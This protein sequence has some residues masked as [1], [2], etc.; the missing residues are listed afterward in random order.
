MHPA[1]SAALAVAFVALSLSAPLRADEPAATPEKAAPVPHPERTVLPAD[2]VSVTHHS[3]TV[4]GRQLAYRATAGVLTIA[5]ADP[6]P[7]GRIFYMSYE[8]EGTQKADRPVTFAFNGGPGAASAYLH[9][10]ALGPKRLALND[11]GTVPPPPARFVDNALTWLAFTD[12]V[13][14]DPIGTGY[15]RGLPGKDGK[16][17][18]KPFYGVKPDLQTLGRTVRVYLTRNDRWQ[19]PKFLVGESYG[20]FRVAGLAQTLQSDF[21]IALN[22][23]VMVSPVIDYALGWGGRDHVLPWALELPSFAAVALHHGKSRLQKT[24]AV[25]ER[26]NLTEVEAWSLDGYL[27]GLAQGDA[28][29]GAA[30]DALYD[31]LAAYTGL[32][33]DFI[34]RRHGQVTGREFAKNLLNDKARALDLYDGSD[35][36]IDPD[37]GNPGPAPWYMTLA[38][39]GS[40][41]LPAVNA[42]IREELKF[43]TDLPYF[44]GNDEVERQWRWHEKESDQ[45]YVSTLENLRNG[46]SLN[47]HF[48]VMI[49][50][51]LFDLVTPYFGSVYAVSHMHLDPAVR[52]NVEIRTY[53]GGHMMYTHQAAREALFRDAAALYAAAVAA[54]TH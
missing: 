4:D 30:A 20:G 19:S 39:L 52:A 15:S 49:A 41:L 25:V 21:G 23:A 14:I 9:L 31:K 46:L 17:D 10:G 32:A 53:E 22:G 44:L 13:F 8:L 26:S 24:T 5:P 7:E 40:A 51:G 29:K 2:K 48:K 43:D 45:G 18:S 54:S 37:P 12:L 28:L 11:D 6:L 38:A 50:H 1:R 27:L 42:Y 35:T 36:F 47:P 16:P 33:P 3:V 34:R